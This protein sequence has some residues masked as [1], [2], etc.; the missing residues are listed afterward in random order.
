[1]KKTFYLFIV[2]MLA[3]VITGC[4]S[5][6]DN[7]GAE[8]TSKKTKEETK[9][10]VKETKKKD[11]KDNDIN[12]STVDNILSCEMSTDSYNGTADIIWV[13]GLLSQIEFKINVTVN[14]P[15]MTDELFDT[16]V[17][18][19]KQMMAAQYG[20][21]ESSEGVTLTT[22]A[23]KETKVITFNIYA[24]LT[25]ASKDILSK[26]GLNLSSDDLKANIDDVKTG[27]ESSGFTCK[28]KY[29]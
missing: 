16:T 21:N 7:D 5:N 23:N 2:L 9:E 27:M 26:L 11:K 17:E 15:N 12:I 4:S 24:D 6:K 19:T 8:K 1:M 28:K 3:I 25:K 22:N 18:A 14:N 20:I 10:E 13:D 29:N